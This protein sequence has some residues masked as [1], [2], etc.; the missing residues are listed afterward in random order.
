MFDLRGLCVDALIVMADENEDW[1]LSF[2]E[3]RKSMD[4]KLRTP[5]KGT[6][7]M[8]CRSL[9]NDTALSMCTALYTLRENAHD[10]IMTVVE[11]SV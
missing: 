2:D 10:E 11:E 5:N 9:R 8:L 1:R 7:C 3:F 4:P 6:S